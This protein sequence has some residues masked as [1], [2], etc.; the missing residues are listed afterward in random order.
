M[1][2]P[3]IF[4]D[5]TNVVP[6]PML[7]AE[8][9]FCGVR[10]IYR[11]IFMPGVSVA[12]TDAV[13]L[14]DFDDER[15]AAQRRYARR[16]DISCASLAEELKE[17]LLEHGGTPDAV[18]LIHQLAPMT[19][20]ELQMARDKVASKKGETKEPKV[21]PV[22]PAKEAKANGSNKG[23]PEALAKARAA[24]DG[25]RAEFHAQKI[26][27]LV[28]PADSGLRGGRLAKLETVAKAKPK[29]VA[30]ALQLENIDTGALRGMERREHI[31]IG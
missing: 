30:D 19:K 4:T 10:A 26:A 7:A 13:V 16:T 29:T 8:P 12:V 24:A 15:P 14:T 6:I 28:K 2:K 27:I 3:F 25:K 22:A 21:K 11:R 31:K 17:L 23:N 20:K 9:T 5:S 1:F 18:R